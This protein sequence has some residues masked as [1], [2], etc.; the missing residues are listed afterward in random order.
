MLA[1]ALEPREGLRVMDAAILVG[2]FAPEPLSP[3]DKLGIGMGVGVW[4]STDQ[5]NHGS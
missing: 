3:L 2:S 4:G 1:A 5:Q